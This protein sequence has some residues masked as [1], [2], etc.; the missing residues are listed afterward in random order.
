MLAQPQPVVR[1]SSDMAIGVRR[2]A[3]DTR[4]SSWSPSDTGASGS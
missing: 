2:M 1:L 3:M 4:A